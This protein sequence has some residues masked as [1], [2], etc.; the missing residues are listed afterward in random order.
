M[1]REASQC[2]TLNIHHS[3]E[4]QKEMAHILFYHQ[5]KN[6]TTKMQQSYYLECNT[7]KGRY[8]ATFCDQEKSCKPAH[9]NHKLNEFGFGPFSE[10]YFSKRFSK[11]EHCH[12]DIPKCK[13]EPKIN[14]H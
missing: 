5:R 12:F 3:N 9:I 14:Q 8:Y 7:A 1:L 4:D 13:R 2:L 10:D 6:I 11:A